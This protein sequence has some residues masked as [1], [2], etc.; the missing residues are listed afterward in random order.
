M[1]IRGIE[2]IL[3]GEDWPHD[4]KMCQKGKCIVCSDGRWEEYENPFIYPDEAA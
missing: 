3:N 2:C 1:K 4:T